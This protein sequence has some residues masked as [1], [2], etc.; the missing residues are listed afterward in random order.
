MSK[1]FAP[2]GSV[3]IA[4]SILSADI[5]K[6]GEQVTEVEAA[7]AD[8][9]H[10]DIMDGHFVPNLSFGPATV[11]S[12]FGK[13]SLPLDVHLMVEYPKRFVEPF[14]KA[15][16]DVIT[17]HVESKD[18]TLE[19]LQEIKAKGIMAGISIKPDTSADVIIP[20][21]DHIGLVLVM[22][23]Y[24]GFGGQAYLEEGEQNIKR[25]REIIAQNNKSIWVEVDGGINMDTAA[26]A[27]KAGADALVAGNAVFG[28][29]SPA[30][31]IKDLKNIIK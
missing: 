8:W 16:A 29:K 31:A 22:T 27:V 23:V 7:G 12:L 6:L 15:G 20:F 9:L 2:N 25:V 5:F 1:M 28:A 26:R 4:P 13:T 19:T 30:Q 11:K 3:A 21:L 24:P 18:N 17:I 14:A 10:L